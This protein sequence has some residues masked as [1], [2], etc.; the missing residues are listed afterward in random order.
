MISG[1][2]FFFGHNVLSLDLGLNPPL[3]YQSLSCYLSFLF[4]CMSYSVFTFT[5]L[6][7]MKKMKLTI[8]PS[9]PHPDC[10]LVCHYLPFL[11]SLSPQP[12]FSLR[13]SSL[14][15][16]AS[17]IKRCKIKLDILLTATYSNNFCMCYM[18]LFV[19]I[20]VQ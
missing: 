20:F 2:F 4:M 18:A 12:L 11:T 8:T 1:V 6:I 7:C 10:Y 9:F 16:F 15:L 5:S 17:K 3:V 13:P 14:I 19:Y